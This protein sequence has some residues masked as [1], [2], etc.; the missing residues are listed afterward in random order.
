MG[1]IST[2]KNL[3]ECGANAVLGTG[4]K[5]CRPALQKVSALWLV[6]SGYTLDPDR[7]LDEDYIRELQK[8]GN[9]IV[10]QGIRAF[11]D[12]G[13]DNVTEEL[14]DGT[15]Q[16]TRLGLYQ[17]AANFINGLYFNA[18]L[19]AISSFS[20]YDTI[21]VDRSGNIL[22]TESLNKSLKGFTTG[23]IQADRLVWATDSTAQ[24]EG[25][26][27]QLLDRSELD[28]D[29]LYIQASQLAFNPNRIDGINEIRIEPTVPVAG[30]SIVLSATTRQDGK[31][32][33]GALAADFLV[34]IN[35][36]AAAPTAL[37]EV[38]GVYTLTVPT[39]SVNDVVYIRLY[40]NANNYE[41]I[42]MDA[43]LYKSKNERVVVIA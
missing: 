10:L 22:G 13:Q 36:A 33:T 42:E 24:R 3:V 23:M 31:P 40:D 12:E 5:G 19:N 43:T 21:F 20:N 28:I 8:E 4:T 17:F 35:G 39:M 29:Y 37:S 15:V 9:L 16:V 30:T 25:L 2:I 1:A 38:N 32:F 11:T 18:A 6:P 27:W 26:K 7:E 41:V 14:E 34:D